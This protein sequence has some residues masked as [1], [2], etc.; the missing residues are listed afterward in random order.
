MKKEIDKKLGEVLFMLR[1][2]KKMKLQ[3]VAGSDFSC[4]LLGKVEKGD[5]DFTANKLFASL[6]NMNVFLDEFQSIYNSYS[7]CDEYD[8]T[9][10]LQKCYVNRDSKN[11]KNLQND[12]KEKVNKFPK[13][14]YYS[15]NLSVIDCTMSMI[16]DSPVRKEEIDFLVDYLDSVDDWGRYELW[17][18]GNCLRFFDDNML[19]YYGN[20]IFGKTE[21][22]KNVHLNQQIVIRVFLN[23]VDTW[24]KKGNLLQAKKYLNHLEEMKISIDFMYEKIMFRYHKGHYSY[25]QHNEKGKATMTKCA[26]TLEEY[27]FLAEARNLYEEIKNL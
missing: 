25:L 26:E 9:Q 27:G 1:K 16:K 23:M 6:K 18:F 15:L 4:S 11:L 20:I 3:E 2:S 8:F 10:E 19:D 21:F 5:T 12:W 17:I 24:L 22:Y 13:N 7:D 14:K